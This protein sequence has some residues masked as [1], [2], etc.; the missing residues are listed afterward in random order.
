M[1]PPPLAP[2][3]P[4]PA[5]DVAAAALLACIGVHRAPPLSL[6]QLRRVIFAAGTAADASLRLI[7]Y[8]LLLFANPA[9]V[10]CVSSCSCLGSPT[11]H[12]Q[13]LP[14]L[15]APYPSV[16]YSSAGY[17]AGK[18]ALLRVADLTRNYGSHE[19]QTTCASCFCGVSPNV[20]VACVG[21]EHAKL[22]RWS[23][24]PGG[25]THHHSTSH[26]KLHK[27]QMAAC[28]Q[29]FDFR[30]SWLTRCQNYWLSLV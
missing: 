23:S 5:Q 24:S 17:P 27:K 1:L 8:L 6:S 20:M 26:F 30:V 16:S 21:P 19:L 7:R 18:D 29:C 4:P 28:V 14:L 3:N 15:T 11:K 13:K 2:P 22:A 9:A 12:K 25:L 10:Q